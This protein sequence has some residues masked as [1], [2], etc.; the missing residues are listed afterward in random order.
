GGAGQGDDLTFDYCNGAMPISTKL[1]LNFKRK[2]QDVEFAISPELNDG[3]CLLG[4]FLVACDAAEQTI[5]RLASLVAPSENYDKPAYE[6]TRRALRQVV[7][8]LD[9]SAEGSTAAMY[10]AN[11]T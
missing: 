9:R 5:N 1:L 2:R 3:L 4:W 7:S 10:P 6:S 8:T 11:T